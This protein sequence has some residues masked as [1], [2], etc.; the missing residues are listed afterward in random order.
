MNNQTNAGKSGLSKMW[1]DSKKNF[2][3]KIS[4]ILVE[5]KQTFSTRVYAETYQNKNKTLFF[6][7]NVI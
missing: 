7:E 1:G 4:R 3:K 2:E 6:F 5:S